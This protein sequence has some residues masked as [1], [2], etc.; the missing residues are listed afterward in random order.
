MSIGIAEVYTS[1]SQSES[2]AIALV[3]RA[4]D[5]GINFLDTAN[6]YGDS[7]IKV[8]KALRGRR[9]GVVL[10]TKFGIVPGSSYQNRAVDGSPENARRCCELSLQRLGVD[11]IDLYYL[12]RVDPSV[13]IE[14]TVGAMADLVRAG[15]VRHI[16]L[17]EASPA[18]VRRAHK[19]H[20][21]TAVQTEYSLFTREADEL[22]PTLRELGISLV[23]YSPLGRGFLGARFRSLDELAPNDWR[24]NNSRF[25]G[26]QF[27]HNLAVADIIAEI[28]REKGAT[29]AQLALAWVLAQGEDVVPIPGTSSVERLDEN[30]HSL[31]LILTSDDLDRLERAAP[32]GA[33]SGDRYE[34]G[35]MQLING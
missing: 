27:Q 30:V 29:P 33:V 5:L 16:G 7:E 10:A 12:H 35:M 26:E 13:P 32:K 15:K 11:L 25:Q 21:I 6:I 1:S 9:E 2:D 24:R 28:A 18:T 34:P 20:P 3:H 23:A 19:M 17:S 31:D 8:G 4:L 14:D 22:L